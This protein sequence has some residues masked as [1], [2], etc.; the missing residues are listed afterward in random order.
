MAYGDFTLEQLQAE[1]FNIDTVESPNLFRDVPPIAPSELLTNYLAETVRLGMA[2]NT[3]KA[4]S[5]LMVAPVL[6]EV[7]SRFPTRCSFFS[8]VELNADAARGLRG[9]CDFIV[10]RSPSQLQLKGPLIFIVET[11][12]TDLSTGYAQCIAGELGTRVFNETQRQPHNPIYGVV[13]SGERWLF[14]K[15]E[16]QTAT[17]D[18]QSY[19]I[20]QVAKILGI[21]KF[22]IGA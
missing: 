13:T 3:E 17:L 19:G 18:L 15:L 1:P 16:A 20:E 4:R 7:R 5:E 12:S 14:M 22:I 10:S 9:Y 2:I 6:V 8:G 21:L 11:K